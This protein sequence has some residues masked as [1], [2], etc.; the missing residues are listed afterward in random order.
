MARPFILRSAGFTAATMETLCMPEAAAATDA[1]LQARDEL[2]T[3]GAR[4]QLELRGRFAARR[5]SALR[6]KTAHK[7]FGGGRA[8]S[9]LETDSCRDDAELH[10]QLMRWNESVRL[11]DEADARAETAFAAG[12]RQARQALHSLA[13]DE[14]FQEAVFLSSPHMYSAGLLKFV[15]SL[16]TQ[17]RS[18]DDK[19]LER[20][21]IMYQQRLCTKNETTSFFGPIG[22][23]RFDVGGAADATPAWPVSWQQRVALGRRDT[24]MAYWAVEVLAAGVSA[25][26]TVRA[27]L[28][29]RLQPGVRRASRTTLV[30]A[31]LNRSVE[32][33]AEAADLLDAV[34]RGDDVQTLLLQHDS[35]LLAT[36]ERRGLLQAAITIP[37]G[38]AHT[39]EY[40]ARQLDPLPDSADLRPWR[41]GIAT[42]IELKNAFAVAGL[43]D[44]PGLLQQAEAL[45]SSL[46]GH[47]AH[48]AG[49]KVYADR[50]L[51]YEEC[52]SGHDDVRVSKEF[53]DEIQMRLAR[54]LDL[55]AAH[56]LERREHLRRLGVEIFQKVFG[57]GVERV[58]F[59]HF[60]HRVLTQPQSEVAAWMGSLQG[61]RSQAQLALLANL[62]AVEASRRHEVELPAGL[63][64]SL[65]GAAPPVSDVP[66]LASPDVMIARR[67]DGKPL[68]VLGEV[69]DTLMVWGW[70]LAFHPTPGALADEMRGFAHALQLD[71]VLNMIGSSRRK[72]LPFEYPGRTAE[73]RTAV[74]GSNPTLPVSHLEVVLK[75]G[76][77]SLHDVDDPVPLA[78][79]NGELPSLCHALFSLPRCVPFELDLGAH[80]PRLLAGDV[81][82]QRERWRVERMA[83]GLAASYPGT[84]YALFRD[85]RRLRRSLGL[86]ERVFLKS[87]SEPKP[88]YIDFRCHLLVEAFDNLVTAG[89]VV[90]LSEM[91]PDGDQLWLTGS[92]GGFVT[93]ELRL[94]FG[95]PAD[96]APAIH[97]PLRGAAPCTN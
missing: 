84:S 45:F 43:G 34:Q 20:Q 41:S 63:L 58:P 51:F 53:G 21:L 42:L 66:L 94:A 26:S 32:L 28:R 2:A 69:H 10:L 29:P 23:G 85:V 17:A 88:I 67:A 5:E 96:A 75:D 55:F 86:P 46:S 64:Q 15:S 47:V 78:L 80:T 74:G 61:F 12:L 6:W 48:R 13:R 82:L 54:L 79:H 36:L 50:S 7:T 9:D 44:R 83:S 72:I 59:L 62:K 56:A 52:R 92:D 4:L 57:P 39:L 93:A 97:T 71:R 49:G 37:A 22:Y 87:P 77:L 90:T 65:G 16:P 18:A 11:A 81:V 91:L 40:L 8:F 33:P 95:R 25:L 27:R 68:V 30:I 76:R 31:A 24:F 35:E 89:T 3:L 60:V 19:R 70:S 14:R 38:E 73:V 1:A